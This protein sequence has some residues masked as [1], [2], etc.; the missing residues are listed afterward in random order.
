MRKGFLALGLW[1]FVVGVWS[2]KPIEIKATPLFGQRATLNSPF[3]IAIEVRSN[4]GNLRGVLTVRSAGFGSIREYR[5]PLELPAGGRK[6]VVATPIVSD[7]TSSFEILFEGGRH[8]VSVRQEVQPLGET[9]TLVVNVGDLIGGLQNLTR[10]PNRRK[11]EWGGLSQSGKYQPAYCMPEYFPESALALGGVSVVILHPGAERL[12]AEQWNALRQWVALGGVLIVPGGAGALYLQVPALRSILPVQPEQLIQAPRLPALGAFA[13]SRPLNQPVSLTRARVL[14][15]SRTLLRQ[16]ELPLIVARPYGLGAVIFLAFHPAEEPLRSY[17][18]ID[19]FWKA[20]LRHVP[21]LPPSQTVNRVFA[22]QSGVA[23]NHFGRN[24]QP[25]PGADV[26][27]ELPSLGLVFTLL[28][29]YF[30]LV[31][32][33]NYWVLKRF[34][35]LDW[36]WITTPLIALVFVGILARFTA[37]LY[38][39]PLSA[40]IQSVLIMPVGASEAYAISSALLFFPRAGLYDLQFDRAELVESGTLSSFVRRGGDL[41]EVLGTLEG[42]P[43]IVQDYRVRNLSFQWFRYTRYVELGGHLEAQLRLKPVGRRWQLEGTIRNR[44]PFPLR[45]VEL[46]VGDRILYIH[47]LEPGEGHFV[48]ETVF[49]KVPPQVARPREVDP[50]MLRAYSDVASFND[51]ISLAREEWVQSLHEVS[52]AYLTAETSE[53][54]LAPSLR[55]AAQSKARNTLWISIPVEVSNEK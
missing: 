10:I 4:T 27:L 52:V 21:D 54:V 5:Y 24:P 49:Q 29:L 53:P 6:V 45:Q 26:K 39:K 11:T 41:L 47:D 50:W 3:P 44:F 23:S 19:G 34:R 20:L 31:V 16:G 33:V 30:F 7:Y 38:R 9:D 25:V 42:D 18:G 8:R 43:K 15:G 37:H 22:V 14:K 46:H 35:A 28:A 12:N 48:R 51:I 36:A 13:Q 2:Q 55:D 40:N 17:A 32:P 1:A